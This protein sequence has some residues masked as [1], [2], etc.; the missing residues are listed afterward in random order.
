MYLDPG[1]GSMMIQVSV[2]AIA[3]FGAVFLAMKARIK[4]WLMKKNSG[5][6]Q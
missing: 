1:F 4:G 2:A 6:E 3:A 5:K